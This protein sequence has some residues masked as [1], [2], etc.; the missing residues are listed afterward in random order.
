MDKMTLENFDDAEIDVSES[1][2]SFD[3]T[4]QITHDMTITGKGED[5][6]KIRKVFPAG[7]PKKEV[8][9]FFASIKKQV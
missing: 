7:T 6:R 1:G 5:G 9:E 4:R 3:P 8:D 2:H